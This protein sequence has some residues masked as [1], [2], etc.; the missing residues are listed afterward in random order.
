MI[1][2]VLHCHQEAIGQRKV[3]AL[4]SQGG[5]AKPRALLH[6]GLSEAG[7]QAAPLFVP[8]FFGMVFE[9]WTCVFLSESAR[10][11]CL[12]AVA[13]YQRRQC[14][15]TFFL[16]LSL[17]WVWKWWS[18]RFSS[19]SLIKLRGEDWV[20]TRLGSWLSNSSKLAVCSISACIERDSVELH[21]GSA[22]PSM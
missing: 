2:F 13:N 11:H 12:V 22:W 9:L 6:S 15:A 14:A 3:V 8:I 5:L 16:S 4:S 21:D 10:W 18:T 20:A 19:R 1:L 7:P 17:A